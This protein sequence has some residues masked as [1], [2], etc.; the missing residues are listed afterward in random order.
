MVKMCNYYSYN[1]LSLLL[2]SPTIH[3]ASNFVCVVVKKVSD[4]LK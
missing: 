1:H 3:I 4:R 2:N